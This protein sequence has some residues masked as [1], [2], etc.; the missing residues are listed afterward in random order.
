MKKTTTLLPPT[1]FIQEALPR[2]LTLDGARVLDIGCHTGRNARFAANLGHYVVGV[3]K[4]VDALK[5]ASQNDASGRIQ[6]YERNVISE[7]LGQ[8]GLFDAVLCAAVYQDVPID[9]KASVFRRLRDVT[10]P[11]G[12]HFVVDYIG[13]KTNARKPFELFEAYSKVGWTVLESIEDLP[14]V[15]NSGALQS[16]TA[17]V[18]VKL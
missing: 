18:A 12:L 5:T 9:Q 14:R 4:D 3:D 2:Q 13:E 15:D 7:D 6:W 1:P 17:I 10:K 11:G 8:L 16:V